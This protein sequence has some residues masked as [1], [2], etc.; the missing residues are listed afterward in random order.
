MNHG[1]THIECSTSARLD[2]QNMTSCQKKN[3]LASF[4]RGFAC[5]SHSATQLAEEPV[6]N[7]PDLRTFKE[8]HSS[9]NP[10][11]SIYVDSASQQISMLDYIFTLSRL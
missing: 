8:S 6:S 7:A 4:I 9:G 2:D 3:Q 1:I 10:L 11:K 5:S